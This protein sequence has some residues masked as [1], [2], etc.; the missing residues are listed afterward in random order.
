MTPIFL[1]VRESQSLGLTGSLLIA[2][3]N[4]LDPNFRRTVLL[5]VS[6]D[7]EEGAFGLVLN[8]NSHRQVGELIVHDGDLGPL[9]ELPVFLGGPV[10]PDRLTF[11]A[12]RW[13][14]ERIECQA[15]LSLEEAQSLLFDP[16]IT[17][18]AFAGYA[19]WSE[20][21]LE[22]ELEQKAWVVQ[23]PDEEILD[24]GICETIWFSII[25]TYGPWFHL[26]ASAPDDP[27]LN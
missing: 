15:R 19:G 14:G 2:H 25:R 16:G 10:A 21:Q 12:M 1:T 17:L 8:R 20:G 22:A 26:L 6:H 7:R 5:L 18:R 13:Q 24:P 9:G 27:S 4:L 3:P 23:A 11:V